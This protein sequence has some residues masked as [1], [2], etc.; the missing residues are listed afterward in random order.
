MIIIIAIVALIL[1][2]VPVLYCLLFS[3]K[4][5]TKEFK[6]QRKIICERLRKQSNELAANRKKEIDDSLKEY[7]ANCDAKRQAALDELEHA[8]QTLHDSEEYYAQR[9]K[10]LEQKTFDLVDEESK[11]QALELQ[12]V[13]DFYQTRRQEIYNDF[14]AFQ[15]KTNARREELNEV[16]RREEAKQQEIIEGYKR[17]E[18]IKQDKNFYRIVLNEDAQDDVKKLRKIATDL[19]DPT[20]IYKL[21]YKTYYEKPFTEMVGRVVS[22]DAS[23]CGIYKIT[24]L[25]NGRCYI[26]QTRQ[27]FKE[28]WR[29]H[30]KRG[31]RAEAGTANKLYQAMWEEGAENFTFEVLAQCSAAELN[32][33]EKEY[34]ALYH[35]DTWGYN[36]NSGIGA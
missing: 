9:L 4:D 1:T 36:G 32:A 25:E 10:E 2:L 19:H 18:Q 6:E 8:K 5:Y 26:G 13:V 3:K 12:G 20:I 24:N 23:A 11:K 29:T 30:L 15:E 28:R 21:I 35:A 16:L 34:I 17:A 33:K 22:N 31:V 7:V 27:A 14:E